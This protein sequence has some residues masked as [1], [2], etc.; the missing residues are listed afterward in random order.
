MKS[1]LAVFDFDFT[2]RENDPDRDW[3]LGVGHLFPEG[4]LPEEF[5]EIRQKEGSRIFI[6]QVSARINKIGAT[7]KQLEDGFAYKNGLLIE[8]MDEVIKILQ[9]DHDIIMITGTYRNF[10]DSFLKRFGLLELFNDIFAHPAT[11]TN[12]GVW[13]IGEYDQCKWGAPC[14]LCHFSFCKKTVMELFTAG[15]NYQQIKYF[16]DGSNDLHPAMALSKND[17]LFPRK[18][19]KLMHLISNGENEINA[20]ICPWHNGYDILEYL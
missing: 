2:I 4:I 1:K 15:K 11:I 17:M 6:K 7:K 14:E 20:N 18:N 12:Q 19:F 10:T 8:K 13:E 9:P 3:Q 16:G 5:Q